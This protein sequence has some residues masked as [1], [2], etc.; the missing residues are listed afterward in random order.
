MLILLTLG[1]KLFGNRRTVLAW[2]VG[3][4]SPAALLD[5]AGA[6]PAGAQDALKL[7]PVL[8]LTQWLPLADKG[9]GWVCPALLG[10]ALGLAFDRLG[11]RKAA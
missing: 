1:G 6:L 2:T 8:R 7:E 9:F 10:L 11:Q 5:L 3:C 4:T